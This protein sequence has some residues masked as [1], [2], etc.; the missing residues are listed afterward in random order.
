M[1]SA[2]SINVKAKQKSSLSASHRRSYV[3]RDRYLD[4]FFHAVTPSA[5]ST[6]LNV[7]EGNNDSTMIQ[8]PD[9]SL[10]NECFMR[11]NKQ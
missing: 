1:T 8:L 2:L 9:V 7:T 3:N 11:V 4:R 10:T 6:V 5:I